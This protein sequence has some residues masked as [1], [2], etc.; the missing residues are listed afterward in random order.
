M[1]LF[2]I[3]CMSETSSILLAVDLGMKAGLAWF[4]SHGRLLRARATHFANRTLLRQ[5]LPGIWREFPNVTH[6]VLEGGGPLAEIWLKSATRMGL[7]TTQISAEQ[8]RAEVFTPTQR[9]KGQSAKAAARA[10]AAEIARRDGCLPCQEFPTDA[11]EAIVFGKW[12]AQK[13]GWMV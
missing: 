4:D 3:P 12:H 10:R 9:R 8:W 5:A 1:I 11:A 6:V 7:T 13:L 2:Y